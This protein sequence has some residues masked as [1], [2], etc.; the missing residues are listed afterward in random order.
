MLANSDNKKFFF[1]NFSSSFQ[2]FTEQTFGPNFNN[3]PNNCVMP[4]AS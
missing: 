3:V 1:Y 2:I 4:I